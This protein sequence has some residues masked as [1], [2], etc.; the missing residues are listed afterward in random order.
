MATEIRIPTI[1]EGIEDVR[2]VKWLKQKGD[3]VK[4]GDAL[5]EIET[6]K[7]TVEVE[8]TA[9]GVLKEVM[10]NEDDTVAVNAVVAIVE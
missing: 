6:D 9:D 8:S 2:I 10:A 7:A 1:D 4:A 5:L 3:Q